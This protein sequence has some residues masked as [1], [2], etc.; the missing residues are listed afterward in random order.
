M[1]EINFRKEQVQAYPQTKKYF[2]DPL[3]VRDCVILDGK[4]DCIRLNKNSLP[5]CKYLKNGV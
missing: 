4:C 3:V 1:S 2:I 5:D